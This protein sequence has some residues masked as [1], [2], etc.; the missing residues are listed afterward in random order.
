LPLYPAYDTV[1]YVHHARI[2]AFENMVPGQLYIPGKTTFPLVEAVSR[3]LDELE[4]VQ[5]KSGEQSKFEPSTCV[6]LRRDLGLSDEVP[7]HVWIVTTPAQFHGWCKLIEHPWSDLKHKEH[8]TIEQQKAA[9][10]NVTFS[11]VKHT[12]ELHH[13]HVDQT[14]SSLLVDVQAIEVVDKEEQDDVVSTRKKAR[15]E[16]TEMETAQEEAVLES[17]L[18]CFEVVQ[19]AGGGDCLFHALG[20]AVGQDGVAVRQAIVQYYEDNVK[21]F[22]ERMQEIAVN[23]TVSLVLGDLSSVAVSSPEEYIGHMRNQ[24]TW[25]DNLEVAAATFVYG[26]SI[27]VFKPN[28]LSFCIDAPQPVNGEDICLLLQGEH[29]ELLQPTS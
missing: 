11:V 10:A 6:A 9:I 24:G 23:G 29:Y 7:I 25:A 3:V 22:S 20:Q 8:A 18:D 1:E 4:G 28:N 12:F 5:C 13:M 16:Q 27:V 2:P 17:L 19:N 26:R 15:V 21:W 14:G